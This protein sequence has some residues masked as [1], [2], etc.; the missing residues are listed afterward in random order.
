V[1]EGAVVSLHARKSK[2]IQFVLE[3]NSFQCQIKA[4]KKVNNTPDG[5]K[6]NSLCPDGEVRDET[7]PDYALEIEFWCDWRS[8]GISDYLE[9]NDG[10]TVA[11][12]YDKFPEIAAEHVRWTGTCVIKAPS[13]GDEAKVTETQSVTLLCI[14]KPVFSRP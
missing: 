9:L 7:D 10:E 2:Q 4:F 12:Q 8:G 11:F 1:K 13:V 3:G 5:E 6:L 14:G